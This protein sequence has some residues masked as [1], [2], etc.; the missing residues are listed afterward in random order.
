LSSETWRRIWQAVSDLI[1]L[2]CRLFPK[3]AVRV[4]CNH[5]N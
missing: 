5:L 1:S 2:E 4:L 3:A